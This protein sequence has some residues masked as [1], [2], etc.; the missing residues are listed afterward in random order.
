MRKYLLMSGLLL[1]G[2]LLTGTN[3][4]DELKAYELGVRD[5]AVF[6]EKLSGY[7]IPES[8]YWAI[9]DA[10][11]MSFP[12]VIL[13]MRFIE[14]KGYKPVYAWKG[15]R[16]YIIIGS[17]SRQ[18]DAEKSVEELESYGIRG[19]IIKNMRNRI[20]VNLYKPRLVSSAYVCKYPEYRGIEG[21]KKL[22]E[23][24]RELAYD[25]ADPAF[26]RNMFIQDLELVLTKIKDYEDYRK[27]RERGIGD[28]SAPPALSDPYDSLI[29]K[30][31]EW[32][33]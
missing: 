12:K 6:I 26:D 5:T 22:I 19:A 17:F 33:K 1:F 23:Q 9:L 14:A 21:V 2:G 7:S 30:A 15:G 11:D 32:N 24:A 13:L 29:E 18:R 31:S 28:V 27:R 4:A 10:T 8:G 20:E 3:H 25:V 16:D